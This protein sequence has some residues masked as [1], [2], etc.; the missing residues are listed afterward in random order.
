MPGTKPPG[1]QFDMAA[2]QAKL[3][4]L[5]G[6]I[7]RLKAVHAPPASAMQPVVA[8]TVVNGASHLQLAK[9]GYLGGHPAFPQ[10][11]DPLNVLFSG[12]GMAL[13]TATQKYGERPWSVIRS[14]AAED[15]DGVRSRV[16]VTRV[17]ALGVLALAV[18]KTKRFAYLVVTDHE[19]DWLFEVR[20]ISAMELRAKIQP[21][22]RA[23]SSPKQVIAPA[24]HEVPQAND[25]E[26]R[27][28]RLKDLR[29]RG[30]IDDAEYASQ[31]S[32]IIAEL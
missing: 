26:T 29:D 1:D 27:L 30:V 7:S 2:A 17:V 12:S 32:A 11:V 24:V 10:P 4:A 23:T 13:G 15:R 6:T 22:Q 28:Q 8:P 5:G 9:V 20:N 19:G 25:L 31:R 21:L 3:D 14:I 16:T 18:P